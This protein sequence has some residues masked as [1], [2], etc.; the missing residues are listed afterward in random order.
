MMLL[1]VFTTVF[2]SS[3][4]M[5]FLFRPPKRWLR[6]SSLLLYFMNPIM[7]NGLTKDCPW[8]ATAMKTIGQ[9]IYFPMYWE[10]FFIVLEK[11][12]K[13][14]KTLPKPKILVQLS[15]V[16]VHCCRVLTVYTFYISIRQSIVAKDQRHDPKHLGVAVKVLVLAMVAE[17]QWKRHCISEHAILGKMVQDLPLHQEV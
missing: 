12:K 14:T 8:F 16:S 6:A 2:I 10:I 7:L 13:D 9:P 3:Q 4:L 1:N 17:V 5:Y 15:H 11:L